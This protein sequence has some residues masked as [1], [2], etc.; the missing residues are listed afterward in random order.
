MQDRIVKLFGS[1][2]SRFLL[3]GKQ[4]FHLGVVLHLT[5]QNRQHHGNRNSVVAAQRCPPRTQKTVFNIEIQSVT[6]KIVLDICVF[7][8]D[9]IHV[10]L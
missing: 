10:S 5:V 1:Q 3:D 2:K 9:H 6:Q 8:A 4:A 7:L